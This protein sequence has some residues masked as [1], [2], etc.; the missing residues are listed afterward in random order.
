MYIPRYLSKD[1]QLIPREPYNQTNQVCLMSLH[2]QKFA[3]FVKLPFCLRDL[4][5]IDYEI[6]KRRLMY[7]NLYTLSKNLCCHKTVENTLEIL[8]F[9]N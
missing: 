5:S 3:I 8:Q 1:R 7:T 2:T 9:C 4:I 6:S